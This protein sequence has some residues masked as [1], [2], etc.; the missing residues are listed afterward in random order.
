MKV[1]AF[2]SDDG[3]EFCVWAPDRSQVDVRIL[4][5]ADTVHPLIRDEQGYWRGELA[6][7]GDGARY[8][9]RL[10]NS[11]ERPDPASHFQPDDVHKPSQVVEHRAFEWSDTNWQPPKL[12]AMIQYELHVGTFSPEST[13]EGIEQRLDHFTNLGLNAIE[14]CPVA[15]FPGARNWGYDGVH[16][17]AV[18]NSYGGPIGL[19]SLVNAAH[20][21]GLAI[22]L[23]VV[24]NHLGPEGNYLHEFGPYFTDKFKTPWGWAINLDGPHSDQVRDFFIEN[25]LY[26]FREFH[27]DALRLDAI[28]GMFDRSAHP[29]LQ[30]LAERV[31][32]YCEETRDQV[33][34]IAESDLNDARVI[35]PREH[36]GFGIPAQ[37]SDDFHHS[38][39]TL[40]TSE[41]D[42]YYA[43]FGSIDD[44][45]KA[46]TEGFVYDNKYSAY[47]KRHHGS[48]TK[49]CTADQFVVC[50]QNHDQT[51]NR[52]N[53]ERLSALVS[54]E[55][56]K[57]AAGAVL[58]GPN[59]PMLWQGEEWAETAPFLYF[60][61]HG[62]PDLIEA[63]RRGRTEEF[64]AFGWD[65]TPPD[66]QAKE[67]F[68]R[69]R[70][71]WHLRDHEHHAVMLAFYKRLID[72]RKTIPALAIPTKDGLDV[73]GDDNTRTI[74]C[75]R[76]QSNSRI[77]YAMN[78]AESDRKIELTCE[79][80]SMNRLIDSAAEQWSGPG[81]LS[82]E[83][84]DGQ[85]TTTLRPWSIV[86]YEQRFNNTSNGST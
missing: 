73:V 4:D 12:A 30:E 74:I 41:R 26:W 60:I 1:G 2:P 25:A 27:I 56:L 51:G 65:Q 33:Y 64:T 54:F 14:L 5:Q 43:D 84:I 52:M 70:I 36:N 3:C 80:G 63:V 18:Q 75:R 86:L 66:P 40:L 59:I 17:F 9:Y 48:S 38:L 11:V 69:S 39:H 58:L 55:A 50:S 47:R 67:T 20:K 61:D 79:T 57:L 72:L 45:V 15:Q 28:H 24:Y 76:G 81:A 53:G 77:V 8:L 62:D 49:S 44:L 83:S 71:N 78:F 6:N 42:G 13:F 46:M 35:T 16:P 29:F 22:I 31:D 68:E 7:V 32:G 37:W 85:A 10:D 21:Q 82:P 34:L 19:K 23:D